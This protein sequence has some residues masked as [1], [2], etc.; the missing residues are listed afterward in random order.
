[1]MNVGS[2]SKPIEAGSKNISTEVES[3][4][5]QGMES[6]PVQARKQPIS[7]L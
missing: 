1:M 5:L 2:L 6:R 3:M 7:M 4:V